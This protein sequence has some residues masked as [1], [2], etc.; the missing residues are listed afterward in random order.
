MDDA[1]A[2]GDWTAASSYWQSTSQLKPISK[3]QSQLAASAAIG[4]NAVRAAEIA[5]DRLSSQAQPAGSGGGLGS[6][7]PH[8]TRAASS[9][10]VSVEGTWLQSHA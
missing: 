2:E 10:T 3:S 1:A 6:A 7:L 4:L 8:S 5:L 9:A